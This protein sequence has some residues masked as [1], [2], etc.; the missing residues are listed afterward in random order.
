[1]GISNTPG[2]LRVVVAVSDCSTVVVQTG[3]RKVSYRA[4]TVWIDIVVSDNGYCYKRYV[5]SE[6][7]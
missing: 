4:P 6:L 5:G 3:H 1:V 2:V 7:G